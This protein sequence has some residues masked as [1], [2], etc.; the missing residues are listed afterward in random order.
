MKDGD[1]PKKTKFKVTREN[2]KRKKHYSDAQIGNLI[3]FDTIA[4]CSKTSFFVQ[5]LNFRN[6]FQVQFLIITKC[7]K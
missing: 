6:I 1:L 3:H 5:K 7:L 2:L 4:H